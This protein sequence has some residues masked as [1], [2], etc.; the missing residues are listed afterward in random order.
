LN[1]S[2]GNLDQ[3]AEVVIGVIVDEV[4]DV[5]RAIVDGR[6]KLRAAAGRIELPVELDEQAAVIG[7]D[8]RGAAQLVVGVAVGRKFVGSGGKLARQ[9][10]PIGDRVDGADIRR[11]RID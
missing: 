7:D 5:G 9:V 2:L 1:A 11:S 10:I 3:L 8:L 6:G 4:G